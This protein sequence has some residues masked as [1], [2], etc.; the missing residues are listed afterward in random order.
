MSAS[1]RSAN[2]E[3]RGLSRPRDEVGSV[4]G[5]G[6]ELCRCRGRPAVRRAEPVGAGRRVLPVAGPRGRGR[7]RRRLRH[8]HAAQASPTGRPP[9]P[10][11]RARPGRRHAR[12][13]P[14][15]PVD[16]VGRRHAAARYVRRRVRPRYH[17]RARFQDL[18]TD[19]EVL[20]TLRGMRDAIR[21]D[22]RVAFETRNP[23]A[24]AWESW[25]GRSFEVAYQGDHGHGPVRGAQG[26]GRVCDVRRD[27]RRRPLARPGRPRHA[28]VPAPDRAGPV[29]GRGRAAGRDLLRRLDRG[30]LQD[31]PEIIALAGGQPPSPVPGPSKSIEE[32]AR[33]LVS[34][35]QL[36]TSRIVPLLPRITIDWVCAPPAR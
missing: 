21:P 19:G 7:A 4:G 16:R 10:A 20:A 31:S 22:G 18:R 9:W 11:R 1:A 8:R 17:D 28:A 6:D 29:P 34:E 15:G 32:Y 13:C 24:R 12:R 30:P 14:C 3:R 25:D 26:R 36:S 23:G 5:A 27:H 2:G 33:S 35:C